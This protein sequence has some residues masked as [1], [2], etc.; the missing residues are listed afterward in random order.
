[1]KQTNAVEPPDVV[2]SNRRPAVANGWSIET[3]RFDLFR[4]SARGATMSQTDTLLTI[5][6]GQTDRAVPRSL[7][8][9]IEV[10]EVK[11]SRQRHVPVARVRPVAM[12]GRPSRPRPKRRLRREVRIAGCALLALAPL[13]SACTVGWSGRPARVLA[14]SI[15]EATAPDR[16]RRRRCRSRVTPAASRRCLAVSPPG[17]VVLSSGAAA[18]TPGT[19]TEVPVVF[20]GYVLPDDSLE[21][22]T[23]EGS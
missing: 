13:L 17:V 19:D 16:E 3:G 8:S 23:H 20:P 1:M 6:S 5:P 18:T 9:L 7:A 12:T 10:P 22:S 2:R 11:R 4:E 14:C 21:E 15:A